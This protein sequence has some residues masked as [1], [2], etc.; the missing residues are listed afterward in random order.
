MGEAY[1][2]E[3]ILA[4]GLNNTYK[5]NKFSTDIRVSTIPTVYGEKIV[6]RILDKLKV[7]FLSTI[8]TQVKK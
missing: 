4:K 6:L 5:N 2:I 3:N 1:I 7:D 8:S